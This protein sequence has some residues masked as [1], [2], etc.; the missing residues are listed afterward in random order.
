M[1]RTRPPLPL[2]LFRAGWR[3]V[4]TFESLLAAGCAGRERD[5]ARQVSTHPVPRGC[6]NRGSSS[7]SL[8]LSGGTIWAS[9]N[10]Q[11]HA[12]IP[13]K[14][15]H[16]A[17]QV[18]SLGKLEREDLPECGGDGFRRAMSPHSSQA[19]SGKEDPPPCSSGLCSGSPQGSG[20]LG[21]TWLKDQGH[22]FSWFLRAHT[23][24]VTRWSPAGTPHQQGNQRLSLLQTARDQERS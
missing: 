8:N 20:P 19:L 21:V 5:Q 1:G 10:Q 17:A 18:S 13:R 7:W 3:V 15:R 23:G 6:E 12:A 22:D 4:S 9:S 14:V 24:L 11:G 2:P 16:C